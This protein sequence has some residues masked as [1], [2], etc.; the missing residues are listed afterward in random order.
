MRFFFL[1][2]LKSALFYHSTFQIILYSLSCLMQKYR[3]GFCEASDIGKLEMTSRFFRS[4]VNWDSVYSVY[5]NRRITST[6]IPPT[7]PFKV[8]F[9]MEELEYRR[10]CLDSMIKTLR[11]STALYSYMRKCRSILFS[12]REHG[13][14]GIL[15]EIIMFKDEHIARAVTMQRG[16]ALFTVIIENIGVMEQYKASVEEGQVY[17]SSL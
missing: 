10:R 13:I 15:H 1:C 6:S 8:L 4:L 3:L 2:E 11:L 5:V 14:V 9:L 12:P 16:P 17:K 7:L